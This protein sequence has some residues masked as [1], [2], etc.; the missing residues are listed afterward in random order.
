[1]IPSGYMRLHT[2]H[3]LL[4]LGLENH[5]KVLGFGSSHDTIDV[6]LDLLALAKNQI[7]RL[8]QH[9]IRM[10]YR[11]QLIPRESEYHRVP[12]TLPRP[13]GTSWSLLEASPVSQEVKADDK[14]R[15][16]HILT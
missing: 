1:V 9:P 4:A 7:I 13:C 6:L 3:A 5:T 11:Q 15:K 16:G 8:H 14:I 2:S 12:P 10:A